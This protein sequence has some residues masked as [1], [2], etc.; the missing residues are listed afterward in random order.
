VTSI[1]S[2][3]LGANLQR[4]LIQRQENSP[5][6]AGQVFWLALGMNTAAALLLAAFAPLAGIIFHDARVT[7]L[8]LIVAAAVPIMALNTIY[9]ATLL[10]DLRFRAIAGIQFG[11]GLIRNGLAV[12]LAAIGFASYSIVLPIVVSSVFSAL[13][14]R[15]MAGKIPLESPKPRNWPPFLASASWLMLNALFTSIQ[16]YGTNFVIGIMQ[17][18]TVAG[19]FYWGSS[20]SSQAVF[21]LATN[22]QGVL[23]P[24]LTK[25]NH[26]AARQY[27]AFR[28]ICQ[29]LM[30]VIIPVCVLQMLLATDVIGLLFPKKWLP[31]AAVIQ[32]LSLGL[33]FQPLGIASNAL[34]LARGAYS[35]L[36][37]RNGATGALTI[38]AAWHGATFGG[39]DSI[40]KWN[41]ISLV[42]G[43]FFL[44][45]IA[46]RELKGK[47][48]TIWISIL[49]SLLLGLAMAIEGVFLLMKLSNA[50]PLQ[51][52]MIVGAATS[53]TYLLL[54]FLCCRQLMIEMWTRF[55]HWKS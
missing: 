7:P 55:L 53:L 15:T 43:N 45:W 42:L 39:A 36:A 49:P 19:F 46:I 28:K 51:K 35:K 37:L 52:L 47:F 44:G 23:F 17:N 5:A 50:T 18:A 48:S 9:S 16:N 10:R 26:D 13:A 6:T 1:S 29:T 41:A 27:E 25:L 11:E 21:L 33:V 32:W 8:I 12:A 54:A 2:A 30:F 31:A 34:L 14:C 4:I 40:A 24:V 38:L 20:L 3:L 22:L